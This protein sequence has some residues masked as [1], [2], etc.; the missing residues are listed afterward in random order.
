MVQVSHA[1]E[2]C[3]CKR[4]LYL[5]KSIYAKVQSTKLKNY[6]KLTSMEVIPV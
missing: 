5:Q 3:N 2:Q 1:T 4:K 6:R